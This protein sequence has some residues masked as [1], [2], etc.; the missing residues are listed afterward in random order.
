MML[1]ILNNLLWKMAEIVFCMRSS[2]LESVIVIEFHAT[3]TYQSLDQTKE[4]YNISK[5]CVVEKEN[6][7][8]RINPRKFAASEKRKSTY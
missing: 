8:V 7:I 2:L 4:K 6:I 1:N 5:L 3:E